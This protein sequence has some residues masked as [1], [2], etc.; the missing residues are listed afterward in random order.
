M[1]ASVKPWLLVNSIQLTEADKVDIIKGAELNDKHLD[2]V[3]E[4]IRKQLKNLAGLQC[5]LA[6]PVHPRPLITPAHLFLQMIHS[7]GNH[8][9]VASTIASPTTVQVFDSLYSSIDD[10]TTRLL[11]NLFAY[12]PI[13]NPKALLVAAFVFHVDAHTCKHNICILMYSY[14]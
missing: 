5:T 3:Q 11:M 13:T 14:F 6:L 10:M 1:R 8:W 4:I 12:I 2:F 9:V 7:K